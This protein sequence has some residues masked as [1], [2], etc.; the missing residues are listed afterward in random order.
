MNGSSELGNKIPKLAVLCKLET[1]NELGAREDPP[2]P[3]GPEKVETNWSLSTYHSNI[4][5]S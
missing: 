4:H 5:N 1:E 2:A 3:N